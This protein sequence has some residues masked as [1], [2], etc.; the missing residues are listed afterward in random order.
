MGEHGSKYRGCPYFHSL[1]DREMRNKP[2]C[3]P[4]NV[5]QNNQQSPALDTA[6]ISFQSIHQQRPAF[7]TLHNNPPFSPL[8]A[9]TRPLIIQ[10]QNSHK[11]PHNPT[12]KTNRLT[13]RPNTC[14]CHNHTTGHIRGLPIQEKAP[15]VSVPA[16]QQTRAS[17]YCRKIW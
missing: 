2:Q 13:F 16:C 3:T 12:A 9:W 5:K 6:R 14:L 1:L 17:A 7:K 10:L 15:A 11:F 8:N 4:I